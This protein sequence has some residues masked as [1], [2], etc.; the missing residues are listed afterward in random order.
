VAIDRWH[1]GMLFVNGSLESEFTTTA[2]PSTTSGLFQIGA[3]NPMHTLFGAL[4]TPRA[5]G[6]T[7]AKSAGCSLRPPTSTETPRSTPNPRATGGTST[8]SAREASTTNQ[9]LRRVNGES[10]PPSARGP[11]QDRTDLQH[12]WASASPSRRTG[13]AELHI[14]GLSGP[15]GHRLRRWQP[16]SFTLLCG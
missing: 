5:L 13:R 12:I 7:K 1:Q 9:A 8:R 10:G 3:K 2:R 15:S 11:R 4:G 16:D 14:S 6:L